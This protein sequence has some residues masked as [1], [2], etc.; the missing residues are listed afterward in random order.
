MLVRNPRLYS[1]EGLLPS[2]PV[3]AL[4]D[5]VKNYLES[6]Q[7]LLSEDEFKNVSEL[8]E[9]FLK[10]E[11]WK[12][13]LIAK[14][15]GLFMSNYVTPFWEKY[16][17]LMGRDQLTISSSIGYASTF[18][19]IEAS[20][21]VKAAHAVYFAALNT[22]AIYKQQMK[23]PADG[24]VCS[25]H[26]YRV[27]LLKSNHLKINNIHSF[28]HMLRPVFQEKALTTWTS[29]ESPNM[30][31]YTVMDASTKLRCL[32]RKEEFIPWNIYTMSSPS[33]F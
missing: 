19:E 8:A 25:R 12:L 14:T 6:V 9:K 24:L 17:Y 30:W 4:K 20:Q 13:Q 5:T 3:P 28:R 10:E 31:L 21:P 16:A 33:C 32:M 7:E 26:Y 18:K 23:P 22:L 2:L 27:R 1:C 11:G 15:M 29:T